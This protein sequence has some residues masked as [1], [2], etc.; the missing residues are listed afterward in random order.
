MLR[1]I[2]VNMRRYAGLVEATD[3][4]K[5]IPTTNQP[6]EEMAKVLGISV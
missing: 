5:R 2:L 1:F 6:T 4:R 3:S